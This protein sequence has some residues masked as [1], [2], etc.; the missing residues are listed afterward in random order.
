MGTLPI[1][2][3]AQ[4]QSAQAQAAP[5]IGYSADGL[6]NLANAYER[7][8]KPGMAILN[9]ERAGLLAP[10]DPDIDANLRAVRLASG[11]PTGAVSGFERSVTLVSPWL[12][13][14]FAVFGLLL[15]AAS[16]L[17]GLGTRRWRRL[18]AC[19]VVIGLLLMGVTIAQGI[20]L[21]PRLQRAIVLVAAT[22]VRAT[23]APL[24]DPLFTLPEGA[25]VKLLG[26]HQDFVFVEIK[27]TT[28]GWVS[29]ASLA[30]VVP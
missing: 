6:Y 29:R 22:P 19:G 16:A 7:A 28:R 30:T 18:R 12:A 5:P 4:A 1:C 25:E 21:W 24:G 20:V 15:I 9:Y 17:L 23:P 13:A 27:P 10:N 3:A 14:W 11:L 26:E 8:G 2:A